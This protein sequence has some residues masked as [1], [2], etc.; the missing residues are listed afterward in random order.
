MIRTGYISASLL[1]AIA[2]VRAQDITLPEPQQLQ[3]DNGTTILLYEKRDVPL[4]GLTATIRGGAVTDPEGRAG[5]ASLVASALEKGAGKR[6]AEE[7]AEAIDAVGATLSARANLE[8][9]TVSAEFLAKDTD[10]L[11]GLVSDMLTSPT[12][13]PEEILRLRDRQID[14]LRAARDGDPGQL[15]TTY[16]NAF[17]FGDHPY[18]TAVAGDET[19]L[20]S[21]TPADV[22]SWY[23]DYVGANRLF[24]AAAGDFAAADVAARLTEAFGTFRTVGGPSPDIPSAHPDTGHRVLLVDKPGA[25]QAYFWIGNV[26][27]SRDYARRAELDVAN[28]LFGGRYTSLLF[29]EMRSKAGLTYGVYSQLSEYS[30]P[31]T[32]AIVSYTKTEST[33]TAIDLALKLL[34][35]MRQSGFTP[36]LVASARNYLLGLFPLSM[37]TSAQLSGLY[38]ELAAF[39][40]DSSYVNDYLASISTADAENVRDVVDAVYP[41]PDNLVLVVI[42]DADALRE[43]LAKYG[44]VT[45]MDITEPRFAP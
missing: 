16:G 26:G 31:G 37:E 40:E 34:G 43:Q 13:A 18:G 39:G 10:L 17:L 35:Q 27:V 28:V 42:G 23:D 30:T 2:V 20:A 14:L 9:L 8:T 21:I 38:A 4:V 29:D 19:T 33:V 32:V 5:L 45:E 6:N 7:F 3:L 12:L 1:L 25:S 24:I 41:D 44:A 15:T 36:E 11:I 22:R